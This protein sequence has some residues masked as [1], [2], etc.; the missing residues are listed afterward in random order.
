MSLSIRQAIMLS[1]LSL[2]IFASEIVRTKPNIVACRDALFPSHTG[3]NCE[4]GKDHIGKFLEKKHDEYTI[5]YPEFEDI[6]KLLIENASLF[7]EHLQIAIATIR[8]NKVDLNSNGKRIR[9]KVTITDQDKI[10]P[11]P[12]RKK[13][14]ITFDF[15]V[16]NFIM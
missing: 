11:T 4:L 7:E 14:K 3:R 16:S 2:Q 5:I 15:D 12:S 10:L 9:S 8:N 6:F 1:I 13:R